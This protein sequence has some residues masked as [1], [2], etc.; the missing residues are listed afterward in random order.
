MAG[1]SREE[2]VPCCTGSERERRPWL[3]PR[4]VVAGAQGPFLQ[5]VQ[6]NRVYTGSQERFT[7]GL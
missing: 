5:E 4:E 2:G 1:T 3:A 6:T 7:A